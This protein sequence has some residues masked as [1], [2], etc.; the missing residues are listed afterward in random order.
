MNT[1]KNFPIED[2]SLSAD[3]A[4]AE[5]EAATQELLAISG[6]LERVKQ[7]KATPKADYVNW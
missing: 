3:L 6:L 1:T 5:G 2:E 4:N 7:N